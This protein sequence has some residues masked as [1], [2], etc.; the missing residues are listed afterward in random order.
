MYY[1]Y[2]IEKTA[3]ACICLLP[4]HVFLYLS[5]RDAGNDYDGHNLPQGME[6]L[7]KKKIYMVSCNYFKLHTHIAD[8][9]FAFLIYMDILN[10]VIRLKKQ[11]CPHISENHH[12][13]PPKLYT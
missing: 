12:L 1:F 5:T 10:F 11:I 2:I 6:I 7:K 13:L 8:M 4:L 3:H 9:Q